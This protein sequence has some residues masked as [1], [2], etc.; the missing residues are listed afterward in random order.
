LPK[1]W[2]TVIEAEL[3]LQELGS[4][5]RITEAEALLKFTDP[6]I[7]SWFAEI[8]GERLFSYKK[9]VNPNHPGSDGNINLGAI[10]RFDIS[11]RCFNRSAVKFQNRNISVLGAAPL[12]T[13]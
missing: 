6:R 1:D 12:S 8:W 11:V 5:L 2:L 7:T 9:H 3:S 4:A 10:G 13:I